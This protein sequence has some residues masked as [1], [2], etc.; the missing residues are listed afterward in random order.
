MNDPDTILLTAEE[1]MEKALDYLK[2]ELRGIRTGR[3]SPAMVE[4]VKV[5]YYGASSDLKSLAI[6]SVPEPT[7]ILIKPFDAGSVSEIKK[8]IES[9]GLG[10]NP[11]PEGK[12]LRIN[13]P[14]LSG[15][16]R[17][18]LVGKCKK[19]AEE[20]KIVLRNARRDANKHADG[21]K[22]GGHI[23]EDEIETLKTEI[24]DLLKKYE[25]E[26]DKKVEEKTK[27]IAEV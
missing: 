26:V 11:M 2:H 6:I 5:D 8:A 13:V 7:Q 18:Q 23:P 24:Q 15:D 3:A 27:E 17:Q 25:T 21:L 19:L 16:R 14:P 9:A 10:L 22:G 20:T 4:Y 12:Q 1:G